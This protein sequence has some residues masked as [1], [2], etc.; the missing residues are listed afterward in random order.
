MRDNSPS[1]WYRRTYRWGQTNITEIDPI[2]YDIPW[3]RE[4]WRRT[5]VQGLIINAGGIVAYY[6]SRYPLQ[7]RA[8]FL[9]DRDLYGELAAAAREESLVVLAR[10]DCNRADE[11]FYM[12]HPEWFT[13]DAE[14]RPYRQGDLYVTCIF[15]P[16]YDEFIPGIIREIIERSHPEGFADN[17][18]SGLPRDSICYCP[19][20]HTKFR[21]ATGH[22]LPKSVDWNSLAYRQWIVWNYARRIEVWDLFNR[23][24]KEAS[25]PDCLYLGMIGGDVIDQS[26]RFRDVRAICERAEIIMLDSQARTAAR[27]FQANGFS[28]KL[29]HGMLGWEKLIP[30]ATALYQHARPAFRVASKPEAEMRMWAVEGF[31]GGLQPWWHH[32]GAYHEDRRQYRTAE[33]LF[34]WHAENEQYLVNREP[35][36]TVG[37]VWTQQNVDFFGQDD[38][39]G[40]TGLPQR[41]IANALIRARIPFLPVHADHIGR[42]AG[43]LAAL[44]LPNIGALSDAQCQAIR[45]FVAQGGGLVATGESSR[46]DEWGDP[47][48]DFGLADLFGAHATGVA[49][50]SR[51]SMD[52][53]WETYGRHSYLRLSQPRR[54]A[55]YGPQTGQEPPAI[56]ER[57]AAFQ[58]LEDTDILTFGGRLEVVRTEE[59]SQ[60]LL[61]YIPPFPI[62]PPETSWMRHPDSSLPALVVN[63]KAGGRVAYLA[64][65][66]DRC[67]GRDHWP[68]HA[69]VLANLTRW[70]AGDRVPLQVQGPGTIDCSLYRQG[71][72]MVLHLVNLTGTGTIPVE[73][74]VVVGPL[75]VRV[76]LP[77]GIVGRSVRL[78]VAGAEAGSRVADGWTSFTIPHIADHE[79]A[80]IE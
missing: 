46:Y 40:R 5:R 26:G 29:L 21:Q 28:G 64:V 72:H 17:S 53:N 22:S 23:T 80:V 76:R 36:A 45:E 25:G 11:Q 38:P 75:Q 70:A 51:G 77:E 42:E 13:M 60:V 3:W 35:V 61:T 47:R 20:C 9:G 68:D 15:S 33:P 18:W 62:Y 10:M 78:L 1:P 24:T 67:Y 55:V 2:R 39:E 16:Y 37:I 73:E 65:D 63:E 66:L 44:V 27:G 79:V 56:E 49:H 74:L 14:G 43:R 8:Q 30:E 58:S 31:A 69:T 50:G 7:H 57:H 34:R 59:G 19:N 52:P 41:G 6:P 71:D 48:P 32:I 54:A 12:E 4:Q